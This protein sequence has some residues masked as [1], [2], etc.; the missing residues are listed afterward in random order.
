MLANAPNAPQPK[1]R[2][3]VLLTAAAAWGERGD[4]SDGVRD[5]GA[6]RVMSPAAAAAAAS[7]HPGHTRGAPRRCGELAKDAVPRPPPVA[8]ALGTLGTLPAGALRDP[9]MRA[10][11]PSEKAFDLRDQTG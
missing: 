2:P 9:L 4:D 3:K 8:N 6:E 11:P 1:L 7:A 10:L 5:T